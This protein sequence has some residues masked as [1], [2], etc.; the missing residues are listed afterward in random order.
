MLEE[1]TSPTARKAHRCD[2]CGRTI[3]PGEQYHRF[4][5]ASDYSGGIETQKTCAQCRRLER[6]LWDIDIRGEDDYGRECY[7]YLPDLDRCGYD[8]PTDDPWP[9]RLALHRA[10]WTTPDGQPAA[11]PEAGGA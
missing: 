5:Q 10:Q 3:T 4:E 8:L 1:S 7:P 2:Q 6:D 9:A 11:Y